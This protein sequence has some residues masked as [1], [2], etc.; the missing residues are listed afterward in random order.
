MRGQRRRDGGSLPLHDAEIIVMATGSVPRFDGVQWASP[1]EPAVVTGAGRLVSSWQV[2]DRHDPF[3]GPA[4]VIDDHGH[5]E[6]IAAAERLLD[7]GADVTFVTRHSGLAPRVEPMLETAPALA[8]LY[9]TNR[10]SLF[11]RHLLTRVDGDRAHIRPLDG[12]ASRDLAAELVVF[13]SVNRAL[14]ELADVARGVG[15][16][17]HVIGDALASGDPRGAIANGNQVSSAI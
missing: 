17:V 14:D 16:E 3:S 7:D 6:A 12:G 5:Y 9:H 13:V 1:E 10:F 2:I 8:R 15:E 11:T 4:V